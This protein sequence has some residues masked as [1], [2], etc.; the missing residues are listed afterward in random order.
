MTN[1]PIVAIVGRPNVGKSS[2][3]NRIIGQRKSIVADF[4]GVTRDRVY[5]QGDWLK[6]KFIIIDTGGIADKEIVFA[7][8]IREQVEI[9]I[10]QASVIIFM[11]AVDQGLTSQDQLIAKLLYP[12]KKKVILVVNK[13]DNLAQQSLV[14]QFWTLGLNQP[15][16]LST[17]HGIGVGDILDEVI[18][19][20][21]S[22]AKIEDAQVIK[23]ALIGTPNVGKSSLTNVLLNEKRVIVSDQPG[24]TR[25]AVNTFF[26]KDQQ[27]FMIIDTAGIRKRGKISQKLE[28]YSVLRSLKAIAQSQIVLIVIDATLGVKI[29]DLHIG[30]IAKDCRK[31]IIIIVNKWDGLVKKRKSKIEFKKTILNAFKF[32]PFAPIIFTSALEKQNIHALFQML[33]QV[34]QNLELTISTANVNE[35]LNRAH[36][37]NPPAPFKGGTL[38][39][40]YGNQIKINPPLF[41]FFV[42]NPQFLHFSYHRFL[43]N[44]FRNYLDFTGT[45]IS[46]IFRKKI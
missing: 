36:L 24:T 11:C 16:L 26:T 46:F 27:K 18:A 25:D 1:K 13:V 17:T 39:I 4:P 14:E 45:P 9:A 22:P 23:F 33:L 30:G 6:Q 32:I 3:F 43:E 44:Q 42:N 5:G 19:K 21:P 12:F 8:E 31:G 2:F 35:I 37:Q 34:K 40:F 41:L 38:R 29:Q 10:N 15:F 20:I 28:K 7:Q